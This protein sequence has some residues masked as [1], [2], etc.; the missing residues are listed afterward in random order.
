[1][2]KRAS[3]KFDDCIDRAFT[4]DEFMAALDKKHM[5]LAPW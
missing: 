1:M 3:D 2:F 4:K 5:V